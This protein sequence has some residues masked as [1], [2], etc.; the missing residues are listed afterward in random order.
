MYK[1]MLI[2]AKLNELAHSENVQIQRQF[3]WRFFVCVTAVTGLTYL[4][5]TINQN[6]L[7]QPHLKILLAITLVVNLLVLIANILVNLDD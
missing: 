1:I 3:F 6:S 7:L 4:A 5:L 2:L